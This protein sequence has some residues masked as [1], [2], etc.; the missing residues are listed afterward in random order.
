MNKR[1]YPKD[2]K[3]KKEKEKWREEFE[4]TLDLFGEFLIGNVSTKY[5]IDMFTH[6]GYWSGV[7]YRIYWDSEDG[8]E[9]RERKFG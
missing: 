7:A 9:A 2:L 1:K 5:I 4:E 6:Q 3:T 8:F